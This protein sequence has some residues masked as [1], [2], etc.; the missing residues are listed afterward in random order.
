MRKG[1]FKSE[2]DRQIE[3]EEQRAAGLLRTI[4]IGMVMLAALAFYA[5]APTDTELANCR[6]ATGWNTDTCRVYLTR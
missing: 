3:R 2:Y 4:G 1:A 6:K 5:A